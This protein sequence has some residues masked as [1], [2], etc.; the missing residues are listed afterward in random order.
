MYKPT[1]F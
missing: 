1:C